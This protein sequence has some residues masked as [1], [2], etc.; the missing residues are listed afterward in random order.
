[1]HTKRQQKPILIEIPHSYHTTNSLMFLCLMFIYHYP[2]LTFV[3]FLILIP[4]HRTHLHTLHSSHHQLSRDPRHVLTCWRRLWKCPLSRVPSSRHTSLSPRLQFP[5]RNTY[6]RLPPW[7]QRININHFLLLLC[8]LILIFSSLLPNLKL[9][10]LPTRDLA[11]TLKTTYINIE[12]TKIQQCITIY[13]YI[14]STSLFPENV[15]NSQQSC[16]NSCLHQSS[17]GP[18]TVQQV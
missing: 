6:F 3:V 11:L 7:L 17:K 2:T 18:H 4:H 16:L 8:D 15:I 5:W 9:L 14:Y 12:D 1:M 13:I 10:T